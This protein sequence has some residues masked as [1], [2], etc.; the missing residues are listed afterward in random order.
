METAPLEIEVRG[1]GRAHAIRDGDKAYCGRQI[2]RFWDNAWV[3]P[4][5]LAKAVTCEQCLKALNKSIC[6]PDC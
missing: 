1:A 4:E 3:P 5:R 6:K 2:T